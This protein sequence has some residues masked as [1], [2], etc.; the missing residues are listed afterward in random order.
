MFGWLWYFHQQ[1]NVSSSS[2][3]CPLQQSSQLC[4]AFNFLHKNTNKLMGLTLERIKKLL[5][6]AASL[7]FYFI[8]SLFSSLNFMY[9]IV[10]YGIFPF[11]LHN[12]LTQLKF[13][14]LTF[15]SP[16]LSH[17]YY[18]GMYVRTPI[19]SKNRPHNSQRESRLH[20]FT[21]RDLDEILNFG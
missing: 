14:L 1:K 19:L 16:F 11:H 7:Y 10:F 6:S 2:I 17:S 18:I 20:L 21:C 15:F 3:H 4:L 13:F 5:C 8:S 12:N 9:C